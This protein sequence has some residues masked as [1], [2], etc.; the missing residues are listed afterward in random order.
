MKEKKTKK[1]YEKPELK[2][3]HLVAEEVLAIGCKTASSGPGGAYCTEVPCSD[4][5]S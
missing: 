2:S 5:G 1:K 3:I 4:S